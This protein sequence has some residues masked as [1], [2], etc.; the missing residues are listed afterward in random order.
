[1]RDT[2]VLFVF[3][4]LIASATFLAWAHILDASLTLIPI[5]T[6]FLGLL[7]KIDRPIQPSVPLMQRLGISKPPPTLR[8]LNVSDEDK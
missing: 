6:G 7:A 1:M 2:Y 5:I 8:Q 4:L 3:S